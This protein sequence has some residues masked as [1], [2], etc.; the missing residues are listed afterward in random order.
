MTGPRCADVE[1]RFVDAFDGRMDPAE[2]VRFHAHIEGCAAC[3]DRA[4]LWRGLVPR[5]RGAVPPGPDAMATRRMQV[6]IERRL[7]GAI[8]AAPPRRSWIRWAPAFGLAAAAAALAL[9]VRVGGPPPAPVGYA[10]FVS[11]RGEA[12]VGDHASQAAARIP[13]GAPIALSAGAVVVLAMDG[14]AALRVEGPGH[15]A[16][17]GD[18]HAIAVRLTE[19]KVEAQVAHRQP[20]DTFAVIT[21][22]LRVE[23]RGTKFAVAAGGAGSRVDVSEGQVAVLRPGKPTRLVAAGD[24]FDSTAAPEPTEAPEPAEAAMADRD[25]A[26]ACADVARACRS[27]AR[28]VRT[29]MRSGGSE[30]ALRQIAEARRELRAADASCAGS[31]GA[32]EDELGYLN[33]EAL[34]QAG[35]LDDAVAAYRGLDRKGAPSAMRQN[36]LY[37]A[38]QIERR[39]GRLAAAA[40]DFERA[41]A[42]APRGALHEDALVG[43]MECARAAGDAA[44]ARAL[45]A[46]Y[47]DEFPRGLAAPAARRL[48]PDG[49][50]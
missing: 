38:A 9:W 13:V 28:A 47:L 35:R 24:S 37:A 33:A 46:R 15:L 11:V 48:S 1:S 29:S 31:A 18:A 19:G 14:G 4:A 23:V 34:N 42:A 10:A 25:G 5:M 41:L 17:E 3:R 43:A 27:T 44:R 6:E 45:A 49:E 2:S 22:D 39:Q 32:C 8:A 7:A 50:R 40:T 26:P 21:N 12:R 36:A 30:R 20:N 16:L